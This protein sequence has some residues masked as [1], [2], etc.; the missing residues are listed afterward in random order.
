MNR[1]SIDGIVCT[2]YCGFVCGLW[3]TTNLAIITCVDRIIYVTFA[4]ELTNN[5][6]A[7]GQ[8]I[9]STTFGGPLPLFKPVKKGPRLPQ[10]LFC[11]GARRTYVRIDSNDCAT[12]PQTL[13]ILTQP[14][15]RLIK[16]LSMT[17]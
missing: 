6:F 17:S 5:L 3:L 9:G 10:R 4:S 14:E 1:V 7:L 12:H 13:H 16:M 8:C 11:P 2:F 15:K